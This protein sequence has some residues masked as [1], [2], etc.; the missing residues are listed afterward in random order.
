MS[1]QRVSTAS[2]CMGG[3]A[4]FQIEMD[5]F[6][7]AVHCWHR[8][9]YKYL[10]EDLGWKESTLIIHAFFSLIWLLNVPTDG[11]TEEAQ[12]TMSA[13]LSVS[14]HSGVWLCGTLLQCDHR[15]EHLL[16]LPVLPVPSALERLP[17]QKERD[18]SQWVTPPT[19]SNK[20]NYKW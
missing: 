1:Q 20:Y 4:E 2:D 16:L 17:A 10:F 9:S 19:N 18:T 12:S 3:A 5:L 6:S 13:W 8:G 15:L 14:F 7:L 11:S